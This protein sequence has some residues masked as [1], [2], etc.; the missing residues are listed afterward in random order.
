[1]R[2][3]AHTRAGVSSELAVIWLALPYVQARHMYSIRMPNALNVAFDS[4]DLA[5]AIAL[6]YIFGLP[7]V[8]HS[9]L[10]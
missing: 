2:R 7:M 3:D 4:T 9:R 8:R 5:R 6:G 1:V 10:C